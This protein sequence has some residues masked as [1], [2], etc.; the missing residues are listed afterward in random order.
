MITKNENADRAK[1][2]KIS[3]D[4][5]CKLR[6]IQLLH[7]RTI[8]TILKKMLTEQEDCQDAAVRLLN[9]VPST[10][11][12]LSPTK[13]NQIKSINLVALKENETESYRRLHRYIT[14]LANG[15][16]QRTDDN[17]L[18]A[19]VFTKRSAVFGEAK[20]ALST[21][22]HGGNKKEVIELCQQ[23]LKTREEIEKTWGLDKDT[24]TVQ[25][26]DNIK[27]ILDISKAGES[28]HMLVR[29]LKGD[30]E[31]K[32]KSWQLGEGKWGT[33]EDLDMDVVNYVL[34]NSATP[35]G[36]ST[37]S[38]VVAQNVNPFDEFKE[39]T[40]DGFLSRIEAAASIQ[41]VG[42]ILNVSPTALKVFAETLAPKFNL[43]RLPDSLR[44]VVL[45]LLRDRNRDAEKVKPTRMLFNSGVIEA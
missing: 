21:A 37:E 25:C 6:N 42:A 22:A 1:Q 5:Y 13:S 3:L 14:H 40:A 45:S 26:I 30:S 2:A 38:A 8:I 29:K 34:H 17:L 24:V 19:N 15:G 9:M 31:Q 20:K 35:V 4:D 36:V 32:R 11:V 23:I 44:G 28:D 33:I 39:S 12:G 10:V 7:S 43:Y 27:A 16:K 18:A 41:D